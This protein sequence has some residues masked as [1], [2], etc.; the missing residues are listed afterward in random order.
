M[1]VWYCADGKY[2][3]VEENDTC[4]VHIAGG[5]ACGWMRLIPEGALVIEKVPTSRTA[6]AEWF[7]LTVGNSD[8]DSWSF[9]LADALLASQ[10]GEPG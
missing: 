6:L 8:E 1:R 3:E 7:A 9:A 10:V 2:A 4:Q 5:D